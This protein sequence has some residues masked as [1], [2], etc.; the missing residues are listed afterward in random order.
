VIRDRTLRVEDGHAGRA[1]LR[2]EADSRTWLAMLAGDA[3]V[4]GALLRR[5]IRL[6]GSPRLLR[7][8]ARCFPS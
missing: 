7:A 3:G 2:V 4:V 1:D 5:R 8:F 6:H